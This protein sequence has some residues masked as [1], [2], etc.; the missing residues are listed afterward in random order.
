MKN[1]KK[2][3]YILFAFT[4][5]NLIWAS[6]GTVEAQQDITD[7]G[8]GK[9]DCPG[10]SLTATK[11]TGADRSVKY[12]KCIGSSNG[13]KYKKIT[14]PQN[15]T[16]KKGAPCR[17]AMTARE[18]KGTYVLDPNFHS[19]CEDGTYEADNSGC[20]NSGNSGE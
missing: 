20:P 3:T 1:T 19:F 4:A 16:H 18:S 15:G 10:N 8:V 17:L 14:D 2:I 6:C 7:C 11:A 12:Y 5:I 9:G 13:V